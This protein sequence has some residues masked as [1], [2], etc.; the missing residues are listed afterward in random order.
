MTRH[1]AED[2]VER[3]EGSPEQV[4]WGKDEGFCV[5]AT[6]NPQC[7]GIWAAGDEQVD[8]GAREAQ[9]EARPGL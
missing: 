9:G 5:E 7:G 4:G 2:R 8:D 6:K 3:L 1:R